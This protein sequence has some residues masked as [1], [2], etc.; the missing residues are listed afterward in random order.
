LKKL[1]CPEVKD[2][3]LKDEGFQK[4]VGKELKNAG[5]E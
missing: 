4:R 1:L 5:K 3:M 2:Q